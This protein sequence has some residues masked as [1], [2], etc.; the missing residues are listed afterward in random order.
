MKITFKEID[1]IYIHLNSVNYPY[2]KEIVKKI[3]EY[4]NLN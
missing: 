3:R 2:S 1:A 4:L